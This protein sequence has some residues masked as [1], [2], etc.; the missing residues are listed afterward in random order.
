MGSSYEEVHELDFD[1]E[2]MVLYQKQEF[3]VQK[4]LVLKSKKRRELIDSLNLIKN[5]C[6]YQ[7]FL[8]RRRDL[9]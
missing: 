4:V 7:P 5:S 8:I 6:Y 3:S 2:M 9:V 1:R